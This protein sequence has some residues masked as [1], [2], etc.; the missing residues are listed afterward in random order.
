MTGFR[1]FARVVNAVFAVTL[2]TA[3]LS[4]YAV[5]F[6]SGYREFFG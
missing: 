1:R 3:V 2:L 4:L 6:V 5:G